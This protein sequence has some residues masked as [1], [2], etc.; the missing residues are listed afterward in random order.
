MRQT[1]RKISIKNNIIAIIKC[2]FQ[3]KKKKGIIAN[4]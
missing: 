1:K 3:K 2:I 4:M